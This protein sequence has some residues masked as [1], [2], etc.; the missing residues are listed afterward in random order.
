M[1]PPLDVFAIENG[2]PMWLGCA[3]T[4]AK[5]LELVGNRGPGSYFVFSQETGHKNFY[6]VASDGTVAREVFPEDLRR[7][8]SPR[9]DGLRA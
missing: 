7:Q 3:E 5:A 2:K 9:T 6:E 1:V 4:L 8:N